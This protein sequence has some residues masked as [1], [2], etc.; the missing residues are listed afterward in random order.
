MIVFIIY[1]IVG[2]WGVSVVLYQ[3]RIVIERFPGQ[4]AIVKAGLALV[5][6]WLF[7]PL[8][9]IMKIFHLR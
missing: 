7:F 3:N 6:G 8:A 9:L 2:Y 5:T 4:L 1:M